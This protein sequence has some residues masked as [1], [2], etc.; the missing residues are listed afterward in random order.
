MI[1][2]SQIITLFHELEEKNCYFDTHMRDVERESLVDHAIDRESY[3][4]LLLVR[5]LGSMLVS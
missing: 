4:G 2:L 5:S 1:D 3:L